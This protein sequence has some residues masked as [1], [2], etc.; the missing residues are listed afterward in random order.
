MGFGITADFNTDSFDDN[1]ADATFTVDQD[2]TSLLMDSG[3]NILES[4]TIKKGD[5]AVQF[6]KD[7]SLLKFDVKD[8][9]KRLA[10]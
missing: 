8:E 10:A 7:Y 4:K 3:G 1:N 9:D 5:I 2:S 6:K